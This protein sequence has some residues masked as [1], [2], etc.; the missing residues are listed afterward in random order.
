MKVLVVNRNYFITGGPEKYMFSLMENMPQHQFIPFSVNFE[1]NRLSHYSKYFVPP[2]FSPGSVYFKQSKMSLRQKIKYAYKSIYNFEARR[3]LEQLILDE[4]P[5]VALFL[6]AVY[7]SDSIVDACR[8]HKVPIIWRMSDF[9]KVCPNYLLYRDG[10]LC[11]DCLE[12]GLIMAIRNRCGGYQRSLGAALIKVAGMWLSRARKLYDK[13]DYFVTPSA[14]TREKMIQGGFDSQKVVHI[15]TM[16][17]V[18]DEPPKPLPASHEILY[19]GRLSQEKGVAAL[20]EAFGMLKNTDARLSIVGDDSSLFAHR[21]KTGIPEELKERIDF[22]GFQSQEQIQDHFKRAYCFVV[23][24]VWYENQPNSLLEGMAH[25]RPAVVSDLGSMKEIVIDG[26]TGYRFESGNARDLANK[27]DLL[28]QSPQV[29]HDMGIRAY[30]YVLRHHS[31]GQHLC[32]LDDLLR[33]CVR[34]NSQHN[35]KGKIS[36][37]INNSYLPLSNA[38]QNVQHLGRPHQTRRRI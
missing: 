21:L 35:T 38:L 7:F 15:P 26:E 6:N 11:E 27:L 2:P 30:E 31:L 3:K 14:F 37:C 33:S 5:D 23:P 13:V 18:P 9:N 1:Q 20:L 16:V 36:G 24:S 17:T 29:A 22:L 34:G 10:Y 19:V 32:S 8:A 4:R 25:A 12:H 28:M